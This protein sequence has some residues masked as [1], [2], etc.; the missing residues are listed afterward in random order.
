MENYS[1]EIF[2]RDNFNVFI[3]DLTS[4]VNINLKHMIEDSIKEECV[5]KKEKK[6]HIKKADLIIQKQK[7][8]KYKED[9]QKDEKVCLFLIENLNDNNPYLNFD[10]LK[11]DEGKLEFKFKLLE[12]Y[13]KKKSKY[14]RYDNSR[15]KRRIK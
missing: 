13:W 6:K 2:N 7:E 10:K 12:R 8:K 4:S 11:T 5:F 1:W 14:L 15:G 9:I 3:R